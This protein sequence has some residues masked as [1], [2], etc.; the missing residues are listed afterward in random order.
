MGNLSPADILNL[1]YDPTA[2]ALRILTVNASGEIIKGTQLE[3]NRL[4]A[5]CSGSDGTTGRI[6]TLQNTSESS[7]PISCWVEDQL[8]SISDLTI[9]HNNSNSTIEFAIEIFDT[10]SIRIFYYI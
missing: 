5:E 4:G 10:D 8:I 3:E 2:N 7:G 1:V 9:T 6:L